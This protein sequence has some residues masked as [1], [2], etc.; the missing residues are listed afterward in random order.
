VNSLSQTNWKINIALFMTGQGLSL[1]GSMLVHFAVAWHITLQ[2]Q[3][4]VMMTLLTIAGTVPLFLISPFGGVWADRYNKK[5]IIN[6]A[7]AAIAL[8]T[9]VMALVFSAGY[10]FLPLLLICS[11]MRGFG[12][13]VQMPA[14]N[15]LIPELVPQ[16]HLTRVNGIYGSVQYLTM[17]ASPMAGGALL[18]FLPIQYILYIDVITAVIG[19]S[20][21]LFLVKSTHVSKKETKLNYFHDL[22]EG[23]AYVSRHAFIKKFMLIGIIFN[24]MVAPLAVLTPLQVTRNFG[25]DA[26]RLAT[27]EVVFFAG[28]MLGGV[29]IGI[30]GG[31][32]NKSRT[33]S[34]AT[35][36]T[37]IGTIALGILND[38]WIYTGVMGLTGIVMSTFQAPMIAVLQSNVERDY[39]GRVFSV[40]TMVSSIA[41]PSGMLVWGPLG[42]IVPID[43][44]LIGTGVVIA[45]V[46]GMFVLDKTLL[47]AGQIDG[48]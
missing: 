46:G 1:F 37:A 40:L 13:G 27:I 44:L 3:S 12:Q 18:T 25:A 16:E 34:L 21:V 28:S 47:K 35:V 36:L 45:G 24:M 6:L 33:M 22:Q 26:W 15:A 30:W 2:T 11:V 8:V 43:W 14:V 39:M 42:D 41:M 38:F 4:G 10:Q 29:I 17:F 31:F 5:H 9:L 32:R 19:I 23:I 48:T 7:D 20:I